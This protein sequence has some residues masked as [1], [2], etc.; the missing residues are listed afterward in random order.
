MKTRNQAIRHARENI[1]SL[2]P[3]AGQWRFRRYYIAKGASW[4][5]IP[6]DYSGSQ[7]ARA[8]ALVDSARDF[9]GL[10]PV[11]Y[12]GGAWTDYV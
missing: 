7:V 5:S 4:E 12:D 1:A 3:C 6:R 9:L 2:Y 8:Q 10:P 11:Q